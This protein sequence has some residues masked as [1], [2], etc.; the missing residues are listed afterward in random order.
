M[1]PLHDSVLD[2]INRR[3]DIPRERVVP[4]AT[5]DELGLDSLS[6]IELVT[7]L[8]KHLGVQINDD[9]IDDLSSV[10]D[11]VRLLEKKVAA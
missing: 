4:G 5:F 8:Q 7:A 6:Q 10:D 1:T 11:V 2:V 9:E 3:F